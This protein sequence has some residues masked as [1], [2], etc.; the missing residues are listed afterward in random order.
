MTNYRQEYEWSK[1][2]GREYFEET[3]KKYEKLQETQGGLNR[4]DTFDYDGCRDSLIILDDWKHWLDQGFTEDEIEL[5]TT[6]KFRFDEDQQVFEED[7]RLPYVKGKAGHLDELTEFEPGG[8]KVKEPTTVP[9]TL[10]N[11]VGRFFLP[12][13]VVDEI[14]QMKMDLLH[15]Y[16]G[17]ERASEIIKL[18]NKYQEEKK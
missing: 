7:F 11:L 5:Y 6:I 2:L 17:P 10:D 18:H 9:S 4:W 1:R 8:F 3:C 16:I 14:E 12:I 15:K 13:K